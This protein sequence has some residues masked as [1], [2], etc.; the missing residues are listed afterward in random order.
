VFAGAWEVGQ[1]LVIPIKHGEGNWYGSD[2][3]VA[4]LETRGQIALRYV[5]DVNGAVGTSDD[6]TVGRIVDDE[7]GHLVRPQIA[8]RPEIVLDQSAEDHPPIEPEHVGRAQD[9][10]GRG[11]Q[12][13]PAVDLEHPDQHQDLAD[14]AGGPGQPDG[15]QHEQHEHRGVDRHAL[16]EAARSRSHAVDAPRPRR[17]LNS[18]PQPAG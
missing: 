18:A 17:P 1:E 7:R 10:A 14:E 15:G 4:S 13:D 11:E 16:G 5:E 9:H 6:W 3:L 2:E 8:D 12:R